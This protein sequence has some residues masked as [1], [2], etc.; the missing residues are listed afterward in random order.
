MD[1]RRVYPVKDLREIKRTVRA[2]RSMA[3][4]GAATRACPDEGRSCALAFAT[5]PAFFPG[6]N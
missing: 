3:T 6:E 1:Q 2:Y 4:G 5:P